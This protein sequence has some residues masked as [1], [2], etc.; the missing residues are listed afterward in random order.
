MCSVPRSL[1]LI[2]AL[3]SALYLSLSGAAEK[4]PLA[5]DQVRQAGGEYIS[6]DACAECHK[7][8]VEQI[9]HRKRGQAA[10]SRTPFAAQGCETCHG[11]G[12]THVVNISNDKPES[13]A[14]IS[15]KGKNPAPVDVQNATCLQ[16]HKGGSQ[17]HW[18]VSTHQR[19]G[20]S[21]TSCHSVHKHSTVLERSTQIEVCNTCHKT[22]RA[23]TYR[24]SSHPIQAAKTICSDCHNP[25]GSVGPA[26]LKQL[27]LNENCYAC[28][29]EK[30]GPYLWE[31]Q[32]AS[33]DCALCHRAHGS[34]HPALLTRQGP[35]L[36]QSCHQDVRA[37]EGRGHIRNF[38]DFDLN[39]PPGSTAGGTA[40][41]RFVVGLNCMNCHS[42]VHGSNHPSGAFLMR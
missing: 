17:M 2:V 19:E 25:H 30:R 18:A 23:Q 24:A 28:H 5:A 15:F 6:V 29:A 10:D 9:S 11:P 34:N 38:L 33:E 7:D 39:D 41:G 20:L 8:Y 1:A 31:H 27:T 22:I 40:R 37:I 12:E 35:Q 3:C 32:P 42:Q 4:P 13:G 14:L 26:E 36:C 21:C 16:C